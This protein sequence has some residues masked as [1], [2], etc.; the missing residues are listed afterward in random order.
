MISRLDVA[1]IR[2][3]GFTLKEVFNILKNV[4]E[5]TNKEQFH[6]IENMSDETQDQRLETLLELMI[7][8]VKLAPFRGR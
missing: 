5:L 3:A 4:K 2:R 8:A 6:F 1:I 7:T